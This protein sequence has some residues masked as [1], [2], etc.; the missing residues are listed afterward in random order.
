M[1][2]TK[3]R[4]KH[5]IKEELQL[6]YEQYELKPSGP[7]PELES[8]IDD[9]LSGLAVDAQKGFKYVIRRINRY[10]YEDMEKGAKRE[11]GE[12]GQGM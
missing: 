5:I 8:K 2:L 9:V 6:L 3:T 7:S 4:L 12:F 1:K 10:S 11:G